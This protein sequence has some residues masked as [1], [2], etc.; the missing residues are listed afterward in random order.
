MTNDEV[1]KRFFSE[2]CEIGNGFIPMAE[3][4][5]AFDDW[6][7]E[8]FGLIPESRNSRHRILTGGSAEHACNRIKSSVVR[9]N[10]IRT[11][12]L[13]G[14]KLLDLP[15]PEPLSVTRTRPLND[16]ALSVKNRIEAAKTQAKKLWLCPLREEKHMDLDIDLRRRLAGI[17]FFP[18]VPMNST[19][20]CLFLAESI[21]T[22][23]SRFSDGGHPSHVIEEY[24]QALDESDFY[25]C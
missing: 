8:A 12:G 1:L 16:L 3:A 13:N 10:G 23:L 22:S 18:L 14:I 25:Q 7:A 5:D 20:S 21:L 19:R 4:N 9:V 15:S 11:R 6:Y 17:G 24:L 2:R